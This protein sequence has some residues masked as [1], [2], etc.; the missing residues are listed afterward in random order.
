M[1]FSHIFLTRGRKFLSA[2]L[3]VS[4]QLLIVTM[5]YGKYICS[6]TKVLKKMRERIKKGR[7]VLLE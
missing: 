1:D 4:S 7:Q 6:L 2:A 5:R 3:P